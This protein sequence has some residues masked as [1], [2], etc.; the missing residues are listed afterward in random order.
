MGESIK[1][2]LFWNDS[3]GLVYLI[4]FIIGA[5]ILYSIFYKSKLIPRWLSVWGLISA[6]AMLMAAVIGSAE[7]LPVSIA[8]VLMLPIPV[9]EAVMAIWLIVRGFNKAE[10]V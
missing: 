3:G 8:V 2:V 6:A 1:S 10:G 7:L 4:V 5:V 9:Q